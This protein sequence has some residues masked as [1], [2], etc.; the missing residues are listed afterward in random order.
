MEHIPNGSLGGRGYLPSVVAEALL[1]GRQ[2][3]YRALLNLEP[4]AD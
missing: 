3:Q 4:V 2:E 1:R